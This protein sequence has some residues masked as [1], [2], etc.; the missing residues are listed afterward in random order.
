MKAI[1]LL[2]C[3]ALFLVP[4]TAQQ[5]GRNMRV[6]TDVAAD[7]RVFPFSPGPIPITD[8]Q[9]LSDGRPIIAL[10]G[11]IFFPCDSAW[12]VPP[13]KGRYILS[14]QL[15][16][17]DT[18]LLILTR[19]SFSCYVYYYK[20]YPDQKMQKRLLAQFDAG[21]YNLRLTDNAIYIWGFARGLYRIGHLT[22]RNVQ[23]LVSIPDPITAIDFNDR[24]E[25]LFSVKNK[26]FDIRSRSAVAIID[27]TIWSFVVAKD[28]GYI[29][30]TPA[31]IYRQTG[32]HFH[33][34]SQGIPGSIKVADQEVYVVC[35][36]YPILLRMKVPQ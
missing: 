19:D 5:T 10:N 14:A 35:S 11:G 4:A 8:F 16:A 24:S 2:A 26:I 9:V 28:G 31:G 12:L 34:I 33:K 23:W 21:I 3:G 36:Q 30:N 13:E 22:A 29:V 20:A 6:P 25:L 15:N 27:T 1:L 7:I 32:Q 17:K 18:S